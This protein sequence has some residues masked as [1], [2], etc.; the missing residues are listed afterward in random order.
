MFMSDNRN[1]SYSASRNRNSNLYDITVALSVN[2]F[3]T[4]NYHSLVYLG[5]HFYC[6]RNRVASAVFCTM[7]TSKNM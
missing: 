4:L 7:A 2:L 1:F 5:K 3:D 6:Y